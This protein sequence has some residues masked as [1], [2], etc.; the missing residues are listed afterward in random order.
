LDD[1]AVNAAEVEKTA[2]P[3]MRA[4]TATVRKILSFLPS[5]WFVLVIP[6][7]FRLI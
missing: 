7:S 5:V 2:T 4:S 6:C 3:A 1:V